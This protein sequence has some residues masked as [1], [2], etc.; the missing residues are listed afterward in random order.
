MKVLEREKRK[1]KKKSRVGTLGALLW[2]LWCASGGR[3]VTVAARSKRHS[4]DSLPGSTPGLYYHSLISASRNQCFFS[5]S[6]SDSGG[7]IA[8][9]RFRQYLPSKYLPLLSGIPTSILLTNKYQAFAK[10]GL[11]GNSCVFSS[12]K[13][14]LDRVWRLS[15]ASQSERLTLITNLRV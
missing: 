2:C 11:F 9:G 5:E 8:Q 13:H 14:P 3:K 6:D 4:Q 1:E 12:R 10:M 15:N 7:Q